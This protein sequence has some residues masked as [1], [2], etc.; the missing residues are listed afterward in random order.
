MTRYTVSLDSRNMKVVTEAEDW[1]RELRRA[2]INAFGY[3]GANAHAILEGTSSYLGVETQASLGSA[4]RSD[5]SGMVVLPVSAA[6][7]RSLETRLDQVQRVIEAGDSDTL[8]KLA[9]TLG[10]RASH[11][12]NRS[13]IYARFEPYKKPE[14]LNLNA[15]P[16]SAG[17]MGVTLPVA[18]VFTGQGAQYANMGK[19]LLLDHEVFRRS[20]RS[21]DSS[22]QALL[23][24]EH[25][26]GWTLEDAILEPPESSQMYQA[27]RSQPVCTA[28]QIAL[29]D[30]VRSWGINP[31]AVVGHSSGEIAAAYAAGLLNA[32]Q[33][34]IVA[35][36]RG[37]AVDKITRK[38]AMLAAGIHADVARD[39]IQ[40]ACLDTEVS[41]A[42][43]NS[44]ESVTLSGSTDGIEHLMTEIQT[45]GKFA[46][47]LHTGQRAYHSAMVEEV[48][49]LYEKLIDPYLDY[50]REE[51][52][53]VAP[54]A[55]MYSSVQASAE[56]DASVLDKCSMS[57]GYWRQNL[58]QP[59]QFFLAL[60]TLLN[61]HKKV[62]LVEVGPH[63]ALKGPVKQVRSHL[64]RDDFSAPYSCTLIRDKD[65][66]L[67]MKQLSGDLFLR[68][69]TLSWENVNC[70][71]APGLSTDLPP[72]P[73]DYSTGILWQEPRA[74]VELR[75]R[76]HPR[77]ELL[78][79]QQVGGSGVSWAWKN[80]LNL[81]EVPWVRDHKL[82]SQIVFPASAYLAMAI[83]ALSQT[84]STPSPTTD[85]FNFRHV[86]IS[87]ALTIPD[88]E[89]RDG[90]ELHTALSSREISRSSISKDWH[91][92]S[93]SSFAAGKATVHCSGSIRIVHSSGS[94]MSTDANIIAN[95][96]GFEE[97]PNM[98]IWYHKFASEGLKF[99]PSFQSVQRLQTDSFRA[100]CEAKAT[101]SLVPAV[102]E[103]LDKPRYPMHPITIDA[104]IQVAIMGSG[105]GDVSE[106][107]VYLPVFIDECRIHT[108]N[109]EDCHALGLVQATSTRTSPSTRRMSSSLWSIGSASRPLLHLQ[110]V[111]VTQYKAGLSQE[112]AVPRQPCLRV[113]WK[114]DIRH[115]DTGTAL[116]LDRYI[117][118]F[119][120]K[121][122]DA[123]IEL[124][125]DERLPA[126]GALVDLAGHLN[127]RMRVLE[128][129][130]S[131]QYGRESLLELLGDGTGFC[132]CK[133]WDSGSI[134]D[135]GAIRLRAGNNGEE[136]SP[137]STWDLVLVHTT[138][139]LVSWV[140]HLDSHISN[141]GVVVAENT[142]MD[143]E[144]LQQRR[145]TVTEPP[146]SRIILASR[147]S[148]DVINKMGDLEAIVVVRK[149][150]K[151]I[152]SF[153][154]AHKLT[155]DDFVRSTT[156]L[157]S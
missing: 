50:K 99:G 23:P 66:G 60:S 96:G 33:A 77:H 89:S 17:T 156:R 19:D 26:P 85:S 40:Q 125:G 48:G 9:Y 10:E 95:P 127:P 57:A 140:D 41:I 28:I 72:Y 3:G 46:R 82:E 106:T 94:V 141:Q 118:G 34:I 117:S 84:R 103:G 59:V 114:P 123:G 152:T 74:S 20:I 83:E 108:T 135:T 35:Y 153:R 43:I 30:L 157:R 139:D 80:V 6:S 81:D 68:N 38:G 29:V 130:D 151:C 154:F 12:S 100:H 90:V 61:R 21:L 37:L 45:Q 97:W 8:R 36:F 22:L 104:C 128:L 126:M 136:N 13:V 25:A 138:Q 132:R 76:R 65:S 109:S 24:P 131:A 122:R 86:S 147:Q 69:H 39:L 18:M 31:C 101:T 113:S 87:T 27:N 116:E 88:D 144:S 134:D 2:S 75:N 32:P 11:L 124:G 105:A 54:T 49:E 62:H 78:G 110:G 52:T 14:V 119:S 142:A 4:R 53:E 146:G 91:D 111:R 58:E 107:H 112:P 56:E 47:K 129:G 155:C 143:I 7:S 16:E 93:I 137:E 1:P 44:P 51:E 42:C 92:F 15:V 79:S 98:S 133:S 115:V 120:A 121:Y 63:P 64:K 73:W 148:M 5:Q 102:S 55:Q 145:F 70:I 67:C 150:L 149:C 71:T